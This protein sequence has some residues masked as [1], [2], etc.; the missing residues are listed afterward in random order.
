[1]SGGIGGD[2]LVDLIAIAINGL[3]AAGKTEGCQLVIDP[4]SR[5]QEQGVFTIICRVRRKARKAMAKLIDQTVEC[6][7]LDRTA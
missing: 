7:R 2:Q 5:G 1:M 4:V 3:D 6:D